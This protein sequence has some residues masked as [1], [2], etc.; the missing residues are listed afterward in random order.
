MNLHDAEFW[1]KAT[2]AQQALVQQHANDPDVKLIDIRRSPDG[3]KNANQ[4]VLRIHVT[5]RWLA[6][7]PGERTAFQR[8]VDGIPVCATHGDANR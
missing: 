8:E 4:I 2:K 5:E 7:K 3:C 6:A 1:A